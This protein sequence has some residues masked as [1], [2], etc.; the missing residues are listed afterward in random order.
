LKLPWLFLEESHLEIKRNNERKPDPDRTGTSGSERRLRIAI[1][2]AGR[3]GGNTKGLS[4]E[5][6]DLE[7]AENS[8]L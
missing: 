7:K 6:G 3:E 5:V 2:F 1:S 4:I 8:Y